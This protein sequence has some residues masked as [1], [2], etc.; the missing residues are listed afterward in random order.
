ML[1]PCSRL[2]TTYSGH[3][4]TGRQRGLAVG[5]IRQIWED[6]TETTLHTMGRDTLKASVGTIRR[7]VAR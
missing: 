3:A 2:D 1:C 4:D 5:R 6:P 7:G